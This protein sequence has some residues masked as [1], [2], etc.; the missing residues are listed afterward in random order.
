MSIKKIQWIDLTIIILWVIS[1]IDAHTL[2]LLHE[3]E[4][5]YIIPLFFDIYF[6]CRMAHIL[7]TKTA[8]TWLS[9]A[10]FILNAIFSLNC[11]VYLSAVLIVP[12][13]QSGPIG[14]GFMRVY[15]NYEV[16][17]IMPL[18]IIPLTIVCCTKI[19]KY[20]AI[21]K[22]EISFKE[23]D[24]YD[25]SSVIIN[26]LITLVLIAALSYYFL[27]FKNYD[28]YIL[29]SIFMTSSLILFVKNMCIILKKK[30]SVISMVHFCL[31]YS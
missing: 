29:C 3:P 22:K 2:F 14:L 10:T 31:W 17:F 11:F 19:N 21:G 28:H 9:F 24:S 23:I 16:T 1:L 25:K 12:Y 5:Y 30:S 4:F 6:I 15:F 26:I 18:V 13:L 27:K 7:K 8:Y 20:K